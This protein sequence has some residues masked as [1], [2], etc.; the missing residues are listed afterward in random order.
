MHRRKPAASCPAD[1]MGPAGAIPRPEPQRY[2]AESTRFELLVGCPT[3]DFE[4]V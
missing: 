4:S 2:L 3:P 1:R